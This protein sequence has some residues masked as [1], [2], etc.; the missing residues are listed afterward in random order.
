MKSEKKK[1]APKQPYKQLYE[2]LITL[3]TRHES[4]FYMLH[5]AR[6]IIIYNTNH[7][8]TAR[9]IYTISLK[10]GVSSKQNAMLLPTIH[11][12]DRRSGRTLTPCLHLDKNN[13]LIFRSNDVYFLMSL[14]RPITV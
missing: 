11:S 4:I 7:I 2:Q 5:P 12:R 6:L 14:V 1:I 13:D 8:K 9:V 3:Q 10:I